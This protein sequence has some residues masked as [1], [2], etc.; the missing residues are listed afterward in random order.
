MVYGY[1]GKILRVN[2][3]NLTT[4]VETPDEMFYRRYLG[5]ATLGTYYLVKEIKPG[6]DPLGPENKLIFAAGPL[7]GLP[8]S[9]SG[10]NCVVAK[11]PL[12]GQLAKSEVGG[13][14]GAEM[15]HSGYDAIIV[16]GKA[17]RPVYV[18]IKD[19]EVEIKDARH[20]WGK[21][22]KETQEAIRA[23]LG[24]NRIRIA[25]IGPAGENLVRF[26]CVVNDLKDTAGRGGTGAV[27]GSKNLKA[28]AIR[29]TKPPQIA[30]P[31]ALDEFR[32]FL[33]AN[34]L[35]WAGFHEFGTGAAME[36]YVTI[37][38]TPHP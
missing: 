17:E 26:A 33:T 18:W 38:N 8:L 19:G 25:S 27:M 37:G 21:P 29:G 35:L 22:T 14:F 10:R 11:S 20:L 4:Q 32:D 24:D 6:I 3:N 34:P 36:S 15:M 13:F 31:D 7:T 5:G 30:S 12:A 16:D 9:G 28:I 23:E 1:N 2:L